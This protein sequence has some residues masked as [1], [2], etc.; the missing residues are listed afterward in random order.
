MT[1]LRKKHIQIAVTDN[2]YDKI[3][4]SA[5]NAG[6]PMAVYLRM[7]AMKGKK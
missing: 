4:S 2:E 6:V 1:E 5:N 3:K 7:L